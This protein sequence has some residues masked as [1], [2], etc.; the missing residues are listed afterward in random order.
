MNQVDGNPFK[1]KKPWGRGKCL[2][3][4]STLSNVFPES[5]EISRHLGDSDG[6]DGV[7]S[8]TESGTFS[9]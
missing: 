7:P 4:K 8:V 3:L 9:G 6:N 5:P 1:E 2:S